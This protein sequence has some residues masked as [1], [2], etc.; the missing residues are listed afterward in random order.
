MPARRRSGSL[1]GMTA[2]QIVMDMLQASDTG[3]FER[4]R[5]LL[6]PSCEWVNPVVSAE[7]ADAIAAN[8]AGFMGAFPDR[9]H[10]VALLIQAGEHIA[11]EGDWVATHESGRQ[12][13]T[14]FAA[15]IRVAADRVAAVRLYADTAALTAQLE[16]VPA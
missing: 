4:F 13:R 10:D 16:A 3:D 8:V 11:V 2:K 9:R 6:D 12:V 5:A 15:I 1:A 7:G 14:P